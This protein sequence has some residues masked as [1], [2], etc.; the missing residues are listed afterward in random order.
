MRISN[1]GC[2]GADCEC[3]CE[4]SDDI[5]IPPQGKPISSSLIVDD[6]NTI[7]VN[8]NKAF[9]PSSTIKKK[10]KAPIPFMSEQKAAVRE[11]SAKGGSKREIIPAPNKN[12]DLTMNIINVFLWVVMGFSSS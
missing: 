5:L 10:G 4:E 9:T 8:G 7:Y 3:K 2:I 6:S 11:H 12:I 1:P